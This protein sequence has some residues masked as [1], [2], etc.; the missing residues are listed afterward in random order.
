MES[1]PITMKGFEPLIG[2]SFAVL[3]GEKT[4]GSVRMIGVQDMAQTEKADP[5]RFMVGKTPAA[6]PPQPTISFAVHF[7]GQGK[8]MPQDTYTLRNARVGDMTLFIVPS[9]PGTNPVKYTASFSL[10]STG[11]AE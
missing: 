1:N 9:G 3:K 5:Y 2:Q 8:E 7:Q 10:L 6:A 4:L 11:A